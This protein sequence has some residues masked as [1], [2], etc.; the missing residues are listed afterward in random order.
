M[1][2]DAVLQEDEIAGVL[3]LGRQRT[4]GHITDSGDFEIISEGLGTARRNQESLRG[5]A[6]LELNLVGGEFTIEKVVGGAGKVRKLAYTSIILN[7]KLG[8]QVTSFDVVA[9]SGVVVIVFC[10]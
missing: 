1:C 8:L 7:V 10:F 2:T 4:S 9:H 5:G 6:G 3:D